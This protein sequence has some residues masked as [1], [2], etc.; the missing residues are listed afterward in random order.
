M[1]RL[2]FH[3]LWILCI[4]I[5]SSAF[6]GEQG[7]LRVATWNL[8][9]YRVQDR[10]VDGRF[11]KEY[12][13]PEK[14]KE[15]IQ[16]ILGAVRPDVLLIQEMGEEPFLQELQRDLQRRGLHYPHAYLAQAADSERHLAVLSVYPWKKI[17]THRDLFFPYQGERVPVLRGLLAIE[18]EMADGQPLILFTLH[19]KSRRT[20][21]DQDLQSEQRRRGEARVIRDRILSLYPAKNNVRWLLAGDFNDHPGSTSVR[22]FER[23]GK[24]EV[25][26]RLDAKDSRGEYWTHYYRTQQSYS[27][28][29][30]VFV[31]PALLNA[32]AD[33]PSIVDSLPDSMEASDHR[34]IWVDLQLA[35][36]EAK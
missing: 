9:N 32:V 27:T 11:R 31:S 33:N 12:P 10:W 23:K 8:Y 24:E 13:K 29:D 19:L 34:M 30:H 6:A 21:N 1:K 18:L 7:S 28:V 17:N 35:A 22:Y 4:W 26:T 5:G 36:K 3:C 15:A 25:A 20:E 2:K 16:R 14:E